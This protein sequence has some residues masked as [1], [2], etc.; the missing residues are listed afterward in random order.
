MIGEVGDPPHVTSPI[1]GPPPPCKQALR[2]C[3]NKHKRVALLKIEYQRHL[4]C[5]QYV[6]K[7]FIIVTPTPLRQRSITPPLPA[8]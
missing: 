4:A 8:G 7:K 6:L 2:G 1:W 3:C 5:P